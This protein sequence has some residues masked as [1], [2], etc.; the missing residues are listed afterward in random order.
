MGMNNV[1]YSHFLIK[2]ILCTTTDVTKYRATK[3]QLI[4]ESDKNSQYIIKI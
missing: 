3:G 2:S 1:I 4:Y